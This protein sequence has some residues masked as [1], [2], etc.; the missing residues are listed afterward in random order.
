MFTIDISLSSLECL[1]TVWLAILFFVVRR[2]PGRLYDSRLWSK[3]LLT[4]LIMLLISCKGD[5]TI[6][7]DSEICAFRYCLTLRVLRM[8]EYIY[9]SPQYSYPGFTVVLPEQKV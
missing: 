2:K 6:T 7:S 5:L 9:C 1:F 8:L 3:V 4:I